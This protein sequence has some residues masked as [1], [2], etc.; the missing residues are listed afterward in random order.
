MPEAVIETPAAAE[1]LGWRAGLPDDL[2]QNEAF[3]PYKT[4][5]D[6]AKS[7]LETVAKVTELNKKLED[8]VPK[9]PDDASDEEKGLY[10]DALGRPKQASEYE[11]DGEDKNA[12]EWTNFWKQSL[13]GL[14]LT[15]TQAKSL[16]TLFNGQMQQMV[17]AH[18]NQIRTEQA[19]AE[20]KFKSEYGDKYP[21][22][23][24][25]A[26]RMWA[27][28][29]EGEFDKAFENGNSAY[30]FTTM[31]MLLKFASLTGEDKSP[32]GGNTRPVNKSSTFINYDKSP[33]PPKR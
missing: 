26:K 14:G 7:H 27:K 1:S 15:Q 29:G 12:P 22:T 3:V 8:Y 17:D 6:F 2:K 23:I 32:Q 19:A 25:L 5:G 24:E 4:V 10:Y 9:L 21:E 31:R 20:Q 30:R 11:F 16:S 18:N 13:H 33:A 28:Y